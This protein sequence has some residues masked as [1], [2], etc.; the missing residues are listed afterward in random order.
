MMIPLIITLPLLA[1]YLV[2]IVRYHRAWNRGGPLSNRDVGASDSPLPFLSVVI[3]ARNEQDQIAACLESLSLQEYPRSLYEVIVVDDHS[4]DRTWQLLGEIRHPGLQ[5]RCLR[6]SD[7]PAGPVAGKA[8]KK[9]ALETAIAH[10]VGELIVATD[11]DCT[12]PPGWLPTIGRFY[13][14]TGAQFIA[15]PVRI[16]ASHTPL[17]VFQT[18]DFITLQG[19]TAGAVSQGLHSMCNGAN[20]AYTKAAFEQVGGFRGIDQIPSGDDMLLM[21]KIRQHYP[22]RVY[23]L[24]DARAMVSTG[25]Q[26]GWRAFINQRVRWASKAGHYDDKTL[27]PVLLLV[28]LTNLLLLADMIL[29]FFDHRAAGW[30]LLLLLVKT[31]VELPFVWSVA[32]FFSQQ[33]LLI[34]FP[35]LQPLHIAYTVVTGW[36]GRFGSYRW[37]ERKIQ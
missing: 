27:F 21:H 14:A 10:A 22:D 20:L 5:L 35:F 37:K 24:Q 29:A 11:A 8:Y 28:Y 7:S 33:R 19:I 34:W 3:A 17:G 16:L 15:A 23:F 25:A 6:L 1:A 12:C 36:L 2:Q 26:P 18:L 30:V 4:T 9:R 13:Q 32:A 31:L